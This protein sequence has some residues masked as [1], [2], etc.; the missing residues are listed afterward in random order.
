[1]DAKQRLSPI[2]EDTKQVTQWND[3]SDSLTVLHQGR[4]G[5]IKEAIADLS[6]F[7]QRH[8]NSSLAHTKR[9]VRYIWNGQLIEAEKDL[10][11]AIELNPVNAEAHDDLGVLLAQRHC[12]L[13]GNYSRHYIR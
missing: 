7:I 10:K 6:V 13:K 1:M 8:P 12:I 11:R 9:G 4:L 2:K 3:S 5:K